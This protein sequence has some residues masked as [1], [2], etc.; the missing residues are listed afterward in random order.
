MIRGPKTK[1]IYIDIY[2]ALASTYNTQVNGAFIKYICTWY[3]T[4]L[5]IINSQNKMGKKHNQ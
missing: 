1:N 3:L 5:N 2:P 4:Y